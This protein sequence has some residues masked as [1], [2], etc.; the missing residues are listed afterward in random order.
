MK[1]HLRNDNNT[2]IACGKNPQQVKSTDDHIIIT[3][4]SCQKLVE[5]AGRTGEMLKGF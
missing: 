5:K 3:C 1:K 4:A 2:R